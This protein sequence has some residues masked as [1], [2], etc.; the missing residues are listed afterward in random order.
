M[1][2]AASIPLILLF[3]ASSASA[4][5]AYTFES[6]STGFGAMTVSGDARSDGQK[7]RI[8]FSHVAGNLFPD[9]SIA[10]TSDGGKSLAILDTNAK[11]FYT[12]QIGD[13]FS[14][15]G[16]EGLVTATSPT[17]KLTDRGPGPAI[18][19]MATRV[20]HIDVAFDLQVGGTGKSHLTMTGDAWLTD[21][22]PAGNSSFIGT[23]GFRTGI[24]AIDQLIDAQSAAFSPSFLLKETIT[25]SA[26]G[27]LIDYDSVTTASIHN[28]KVQDFPSSDFIVPPDLKRVES[29]WGKLLKAN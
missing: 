24:P 26:K 19:G 9:G 25:L 12:V 16:S 2:S 14:G 29:P 21:A 20:V 10:V 17:V 22:I 8:H 6:T 13:L 3:V 15:L 5:V 4:G 18:D 7:M 1:K 27:G 11:T 28:V 23:N